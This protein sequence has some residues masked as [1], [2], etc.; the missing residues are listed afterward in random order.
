M[1]E[2]QQARARSSWMTAPVRCGQWTLAR[3]EI[4][5]TVQPTKWP[6]ARVELFHETR[7]HKLSIATGAGGT[8]A[9]LNA[10][11]DVIGRNAE[12]IELRA[13]LAE[14]SGVAATAVHVRVRIDGLEYDGQ[15]DCGDLIVS[16]VAAFLEAVC[17]ASLV[18]IGAV[19]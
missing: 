2:K 15:A 10:I 13:S 18:G 12:L 5:S 14:S 3:I 16:T 11:A 1:N 19:L 17:S 7:G 9:A 6:V 4:I 8:D